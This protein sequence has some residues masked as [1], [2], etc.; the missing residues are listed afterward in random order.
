[1]CPV[2][3]P[4]DLKIRRTISRLRRSVDLLKH[5]LCSTSVKLRLGSKRVS[6]TTRLHVKQT[7]RCILARKCL[8]CIVCGFSYISGNCPTNWN[9]TNGPHV[10]Q[11]TIVEFLKMIAVLKCLTDLYKTKW[12]LTASGKIHG[13][14]LAR[15]TV[16]NQKF[17]TSFKY[18]SRDRTIQYHS[19]TTANLRP[20]KKNCYYSN[21]M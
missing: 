7:T 17:P 21:Y 18:T 10:E 1:M 3:K 15:S 13:C 20:N 8:M 12:W 11:K 5:E 9:M 4:S 19:P 14:K 2:C 6:S 16:M